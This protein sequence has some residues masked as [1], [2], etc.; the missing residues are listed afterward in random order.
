MERS[1]EV[2][3]DIFDSRGRRVRQ[4]MLARLPAGQHDLVWDGRGDRGEPLSSGIYLCR[5]AGGGTELSRRMTLL[6]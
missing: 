5:I 6:K 2:R 3:A 1:G 4:L